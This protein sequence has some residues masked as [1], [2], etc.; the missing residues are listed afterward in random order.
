MNKLAIYP[1]T[2]DPITNGHVNIIQKASKLFDN[3]IVA[4]AH[5]T[6]KSPLFSLEERTKLCQKAVQDIPNV[7]V[8][9]FA[10]LIVNYAEQKKSRTLIRGL[11]AVSDFEYELQQS[12]ANKKL[13]PEIETIFFLPDFKNLYLSSSMVRQIISLGGDL[14]DFVPQAVGTAILA[15]MRKK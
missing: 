14:K 1:G 4:V 10:G 2:F 15:K 3:I 8:E 12:L 7:Q 5:D 11:R 13:S 9:S 6:G